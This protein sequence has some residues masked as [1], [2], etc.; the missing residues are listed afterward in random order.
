MYSSIV[1]LW[2]CNAKDALDRINP[3]WTPSRNRHCYRDAAHW[4]NKAAAFHL[5]EQRLPKMPG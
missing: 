1:K 2:I 3:L 5:A 4:A